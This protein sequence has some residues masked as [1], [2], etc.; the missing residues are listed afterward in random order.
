M[1]IS[2]GTT[3]S[4]SGTGVSS[5]TFSVTVA[6]TANNVLVCAVGVKG[7][8][9]IDSVTFNSVAMTQG[10]YMSTGSGGY[11]KTYY[12]KNADVTTANVVITLSG[13][14]GGVF[15][16]AVPFYGAD[17]GGAS[18]TGTAVGTS[19]TVSVTTTRANS[20]IV[21]GIVTSGGNSG[22]NLVDAGGQTGWGFASVGTN[23]NNAQGA[24]A[25]KSAPTITAYT[26]GWSHTGSNKEYMMSAIE[27][28][29]II[30]NYPI[31][32]AQGSYALTG[33]TLGFVYGRKVVLAMGSY[34]LTGFS[35]LFTYFQKWIR[36]SKNISVDSTPNKSSSSWT[37]S[38]ASK[39][40]STQTN[41]IKN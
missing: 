15:G 18:G 8:V 9:T 39:N 22:E 41:Q 30:I 33:Y 24:G 13:G 26:L 6:A 12:L 38:P 34:A 23:P 31:T 20:Y 4:S 3:Y 16:E 37:P 35:L 21:G 7:G 14:A 17:T 28:R 40:I 10:A 11:H 5:L 29:Q 19:S 2:V 25:Y 27:V 32:L 1:A 36:G